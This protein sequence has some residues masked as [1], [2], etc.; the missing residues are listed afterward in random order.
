MIRRGGTNEILSVSAE[1]FPGLWFGQS[2]ARSKLDKLKQKT[3][4]PKTILFIKAG[5]PLSERAKPGFL[6]PISHVGQSQRGSNDRLQDQG[7]IVNAP[8]T[9]NVS[10]RTD[11]FPP[12]IE[13]LHSTG[14]APEHAENLHL[15]GGCNSQR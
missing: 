5:S 10:M 2:S 7:Q 4:I 9:S 15:Y 11:A 1:Y 8:R 12:F 6:H 14:A 13:S 3:T